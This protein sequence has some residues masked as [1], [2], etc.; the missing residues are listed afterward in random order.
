[1]PF[2]V[3]TAA[4]SFHVQSANKVLVAVTPAEVIAQYEAPFREAGLHPGLVI[5]AALAL[6]EFLPAAGSYLVAY[7]NSGP[8]HSGGWQRRPDAGAVA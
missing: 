8:I 7:R 3:D 5:P 6:L 2:D 1:M 4:V